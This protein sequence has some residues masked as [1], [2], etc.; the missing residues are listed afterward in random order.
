M[1]NQ[2]RINVPPPEGP[3]SINVGQTLTIHAARPCHFCCSIGANF[4]PDI[5]SLEL[6]A[7][8]T[9][10]VAQTAGTGNYNSS[11][12]NTT[13]NPNGGAALTACKSIQINP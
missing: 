4:S 6:S 1:P 13:C 2:P 8:D 5:T 10:Y 9:T 12:P 11:D 3:I 7:G